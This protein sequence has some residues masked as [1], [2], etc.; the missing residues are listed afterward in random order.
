MRKPILIVCLFFLY[1]FLYIFAKKN[2]INYGDIGIEKPYCSF[3]FLEKNILGDKTKCCS[4]I[5]NIWKYQNVIN[6]K[7][8]YKN[9]KSIFKIGRY[10]NHNPKLVKIFSNEFYNFFYEFVYAKSIKYPSYINFIW[11]ESHLPNVDRQIYEWKT[12]PPKNG[13]N[14]CE[15]LHLNNTLWDDYYSFRKMRR[16][17]ELDDGTDE[18]ED[19]D[20]DDEEEEEEEEETDVSPGT[21][22]V[23]SPDEA[24]ESE[25]ELEE[26]ENDINID[27]INDKYELTIDKSIFAEG[28]KGNFTGDNTN[29]DYVCDF[30]KHIKVSESK[31]TEK[32]CE[33]N[34]VKPI[35][36]INII[37]PTK[38][39][40]N[41]EFEN[42]TYFPK[43]APYIVLVKTNEPEKEGKIK[44][45]EKR[46][47]DLLYGTIIPKT[48]NGK[49]NNFN[50]GSIRFIL[51]SIVVK[52]TTFYI[53]CDN[54]KSKKDTFKG[55]KGIAK[56]SVMPYGSIEKG[57]NYSKNKNHL[58]GI[59]IDIEEK[60]KQ[61]D[62][63]ENVIDNNGKGNMPCFFQLNAGEAGGIIFPENYKSSTCFEE[64]IEYNPNKKWDR[65]K[66]EINELINGAII[67]KSDINYKY[68]NAKYIGIPT[69]YRKS[70]HIFCTITTTDNKSHMVY[71]SINQE[72]NM[73]AFDLFESFIRLNKMTE[74][75][76]K[77]G[78]KNEYM[79]DFTN[80]LDATH[81][82]NENIKKVIICRK[83]LK[84]FDV[85]R[86]KCDFNKTKNKNIEMI[87][88][89]IKEKQ[90]VLKLDSDVQF[91]LLKLYMKLN[92]KLHRYVHEYPPLLIFPLNI[93]SKL[94]LKKNIIFKNH[95]YEKYFNE[96]PNKDG[97][98]VNLLTYLKSLD[99]LSM[100]TEME[101][102]NLDVNDSDQNVVDISF[103]VPAYIYNDN[104][105]YFVFGCNNTNDNGKIGIVELI[106]SKNEEIIKGCNFHSDVLEH[107]SNNVKPGEAECKIDAYPNDII[108]F[109]CQKNQYSISSEDDIDADT[110][111][112]LENVKV[113]PNDC[114]DSINMGSTKK[115]L[116]NVLPGV[117]TYHNRSR[118]MP[119][120]FKVPYHNNELDVTFECSCLM[121][122]KTNKISV[123]VKALN[124]KGPKEYEKSEIKSTPSIVDDDVYVCPH[125]HAIEAKLIKWN[126]KDTEIIDS[127]EINVKRFRS[128]AQLTCPNNNFSMHSN[129]Q[130]TYNISKPNKIDE[131]K[132]FNEFELNK[133]IPHS[134]ILVDVTESSNDINV[135]TYNVYLFFPYYIKDDYEIN[136][137]CDNTHTKYENK[138]G[139]KYIYNIKIPKRQKKVKGCN[140]NAN[141]KSE[142]FENGE[143]IKLDENT[144]TCKIDVKPKDVIAF[145]CPPG[146]VKITNCFKDAIID[147]KLTNLSTILHLNNNISSWTYGHKTSYL[148]IPAVIG[149]DS[150]LTCICVGFKKNYDIESVLSP[151]FLNEVYKKLGIVNTIYTNPIV[152]SK[153]V[154]YNSKLFEKY[155]ENKIGNFFDFIKNAKISEPDSDPQNI[156]ETLFIENCDKY[157]SNIKQD[158]YYLDKYSLL[159]GYDVWENTYDNFLEDTIIKDIESF[160]KNDFKIYTLEVNLKPS[161][162]IKPIQLTDDKY[163][164]DFSKNNLIIPQNEMGNIPQDI[165]C[166]TILSPLDTLYVKCPTIKSKYSEAE[167]AIEDEDDEYE[168]EVIELIDRLDVPETDSDVET[169][170]NVLLNKETYTKYFSSLTL[171]PKSFFSS[172][173]NYLYEVEEKAET[174]LK[175]SIFTEMKVLKKSNPHI[176]YASIIIPPYIESNEILKVECDNTGYKEGGKI[177]GYNG[178]TYIE[179]SRH[180]YKIKGCDFTQHES[181]IL[182]KGTNSLENDETCNIEVYANEPFGIMCAANYTLEPK[183]CFYK[184]YDKKNNIKDFKELIPNATIL[185]LKDSKQ[186]IAYAKVPNDYVYKLEFSCKCKGKYNKEKTV[187]I[188]L[189]NGEMEYDDL[190]IVDS[191]KANN[192]NLCNFFENNELSLLNASNKIVLCKMNPDLFSEVTVLLPILGEENSEQS[193]YKKY[194]TT[195]ELEIDNDIKFIGDDKKK[196]ALS[197]ILK[198]VIGNRIFNFKKIKQTI[199]GQTKGIGFSFLVPPVLENINLKFQINEKTDVES[200]LKPKGLVYIF[201]KK[202]VDTNILKV[203]DF[204][205]GKTNLI[206]NHIHNL[207]KKCNI[208]IKGGDIFGI[209]CPKGFTLFPKGCF[210][211]VILEYYN[212]SNNEK[213]ENIMNIKNYMNSVQEIIYNPKPKEIKELLDEGYND[214]EH[215]EN[216]SNFSNI[217]EILK[218]KNYNMGN[219]KWDYNKYDSSSYAQ[220]PESFD[221]ALKFSCSCYNPQ[222]EMSGLMTVQSEN[223]NFENKQTEKA[224][225][226]NNIILPYKNKVNQNL[227][228][229]S[230]D[231]N[232]MCNKND[233]YFYKPDNIIEKSNHYL[234]DYSDE[235]FFNFIGEK[236][237]KRNVCK[238]NANKFDIITI[239]C[240]YTKNDNPPKVE[241]EQDVSTNDENK[242][243]IHFD[244]TEYVTYF[245]ETDKTISLRDIYLKDFYGR[246]KEEFN[247]LNILSTNPENN[248]IYYPKNI[249]ND[250]IINNKIVK[251]Q[252]ALP[253]LI[254]LNSKTEDN[255]E[256]N[257]LQTDGTSTFI[258]P[259]FIKKD[260][261]F[262]VVCGKYITENSKNYISLGVVYVNISANLNQ[263]NGCDFVNP[264][265]SSDS[266]FIHK[267]N[268][269][270]NLICEIDLVPNRIVGI[271]C[272]NKKLKPENCFSQM[273]YIKESEFNGSMESFNDSTNKVDITSFIKNAV[274]INNIERSNNTYSYLI[275]PNYVDLDANMDQIFICTCDNKYIAKI[276]TDPESIKAENKHKSETRSCEYD[277]VNKIAR[278][279]IMEGMETNV[280]DV[281]STVITYNVNLSRWDRLI[282][283]YPTSN[284][285]QFESSFVNPF[286]LK[287]KVLYNNMPT[288]IDDILPGA[289]VY[290]KYDPRTKL[291]EY[292][293]RI[294]PY[295]P[296]HIQFAIEFNN[297]YTLANCNEEKVQGNIAYINVNVNQGYKEISGC[298][299]TGKYSNLF[300]KSFNSITNGTE[301]CTIH[302]TSNNKFA[303]FACPSN[304][305]VKPNNCF[306]NIYDNKDSQKVKKISEI[307]NNAEYDYIKYNSKGYTLSYVTFN[308]EN[309][310]QHISCQCIGENSTYNINVIFEPFS[311]RQ[312][313]SILR[314]FIKYV[315]LNPDTFS[316]YLRRSK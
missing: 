252:T 302:L 93:I 1:F 45:K 74:V 207:E 279:N 147:N 168:K 160:E 187:N 40:G 227:E 208:N 166:Y 80:R 65:N 264:E 249:L 200:V 292:T 109:N 31:E 100:N 185:S 123:T 315:Q 313:M 10:N 231:T 63:V 201:I 170:P 54:S 18:D 278:C 102:I 69:S 285:F 312:P 23:A 159:S 130:L 129:I 94:E 66:K 314:P 255:D 30:R 64:V 152:S 13:I 183:N 46:I 236:K 237:I 298:D 193:E 17:D 50:R 76:Q 101:S 19:D 304:Y 47:A 307:S 179:V 139:G 126:N 51:P 275:L 44:F 105:Y 151:K 239:K 142:M 301:E 209:I 270:N 87:P 280:S 205:S 295:I 141:I 176:S 163:V 59:N 116:V 241:K 135:D 33:L 20:D 291:I 202:N 12:D 258:I 56:I 146:T 251:L 169:D 4:N 67:Y 262:Q 15:N 39:S 293:L 286:N 6:K 149:I 299:F 253:G 267:K 219:M 122:S 113:E 157:T 61:I 260:F 36:N 72:I 14:F 42:I 229:D 127:C 204:T 276:K 115:Y 156:I 274:S 195:P 178:I 136:V 250:V 238:I 211:S 256:N 222:N 26:I 3:K 303:G 165:S 197:S 28:R 104:P 11:L 154:K 189:N 158:E 177:A 218:F 213:D 296:K 281:N 7:K 190:N 137:V 243:V 254:F 182:T 172:V 230:I 245:N 48:H 191:V 32:V 2:D 138:R 167:R 38:D 228:F 89:S 73:S 132:T 119:R 310:E 96:A 134:E 103:Q 268:E 288:Y 203:C 35:A 77:V 60:E 216:F 86:L 107:F 34:I 131:Y 145:E 37:C 192:I 58:F 259:P 215:M 75:A 309:K 121:G 186:D 289:I 22:P 261:H 224:I 143:I 114:F 91:L 70:L 124:D 78:Q 175:G 43:R 162:L 118:S 21:V 41:G 128:Y 271:N 214:L 174:V 81:D 257:Q 277:Y 140:F 282:I 53:I 79:C 82:N 173:T 57:C 196:H 99:V 181:T 308:N 55:K 225:Y 223:L 297:R 8:N 212:N 97:L 269:K 221:T 95:K 194:N 294:P 120:Y 198:G 283:K 242:I 265:N 266:I 300:T 49:K 287:E 233:E 148:E 112:D 247:E 111:V 220:V 235:N 226:E 273:Y 184:V 234:C 232:N 306:A 108:G 5:F 117:Q 155:K 16:L 90:H 210:S 27:Q 305:I 84:E 68:F 25:A 263:I 88:G 29:N 284:K 240:P 217:T 150:P 246:T 144:N 199:D 188:L 83:K 311:P 272:P 92:S 171:K 164:C 316:K 106:I 62:G 71:L 125:N 180:N 153:S 85:F 110:D 9:P 161:K 98:L 206:G 133:L 290:N 248:N 24:P 244:D 52:P